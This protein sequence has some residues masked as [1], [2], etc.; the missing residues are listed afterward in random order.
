MRNVL[1]IVASQSVLIESA[2][3]SAADKTWVIVDAGHESSTVIGYGVAG[4]RKELTD[5]RVGWKA[6]HIRAAESDNLFRIATDV[7]EEIGPVARMRTVIISQTLLAGDFFGL[8]VG[9]SVVENIAFGC[10]WLEETE[11]VFANGLWISGRIRS[12]FKN[13]FAAVG[14]PM[15]IAKVVD[16]SSAIKEQSILASL[17]RQGS[18][19]TLVKLVAVLRVSVCLKTIRLRA[20]TDVFVGR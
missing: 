2:A 15:V 6:G 4:E 16:G 8:A 9:A 18:I 20:R 11:R 19:C 1:R 12:Q 3:I 10:R 13:A 7:E 17:K 5:E 14:G